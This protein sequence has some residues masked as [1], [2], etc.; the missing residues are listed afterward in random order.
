MPN[1]LGRADYT[2]VDNATGYMALAVDIID[3][4]GAG[5]QTQSHGKD[6]PRSRA[7]LR[8][9]VRGDTPKRVKGIEPSTFSLGS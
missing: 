6:K 7:T 9:D 2:H 8:D 1:R 4:S 5:L 3:R